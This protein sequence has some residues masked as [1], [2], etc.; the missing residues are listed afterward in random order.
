MEFAIELIGT[1]AQ[2][3]WL[4]IKGLFFSIVRIH[5]VNSK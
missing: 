4:L 3:I 2:I 5:K 1:L